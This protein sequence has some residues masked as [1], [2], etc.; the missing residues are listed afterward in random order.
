MK[1]LRQGS[2]FSPILF[3]IVSDM[4]AIIINR[5]KK[6]GQVNGLI[7]HLVDGGVSVLHYMDDTII[8]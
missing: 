7:P 5:G 3:S 4:L 1:E 8:F 2:P 6:N